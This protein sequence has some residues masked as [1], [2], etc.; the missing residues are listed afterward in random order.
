M[1]FDSGCV[2]RSKKNDDK[3]AYLPTK[4]LVKSHTSSPITLK[5]HCDFKIKTCNNAGEGRG[6]AGIQKETNNIRRDKSQLRRELGFDGTPLEGKVTQKK[7][8]KATPTPLPTA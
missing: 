7:A 1:C 5:G 4:Q 3:N 8:D 2:T 6:T